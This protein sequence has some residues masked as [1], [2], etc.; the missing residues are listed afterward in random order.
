MKRKARVYHQG[1]LAGHLE[2][3]ERGAWVF[4]YEAGYRGHPVS[5]SLGVREEPYHFET[6]PPPFEGLLP[7]GENLDALLGN[8]GIDRDD[9]FRQLMAVGQDV[10]GALT[11]EEA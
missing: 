5:L 7:E 1:K 6:F 3:D 4:R 2:E 8:L 10:V 9:L 11:F